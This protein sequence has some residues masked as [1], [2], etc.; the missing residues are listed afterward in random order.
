MLKDSTDFDYTVD[1]LNKELD[2][3]I[4]LQDEIMESDKMNSSLKSIES[5]LNTLYEKTRYLEDIIDYAKTFLTIKI[6]N[7][8]SD[9]D[10]SIKS[11]EDLSKINKNLG[12]I[13]YN[14]PFI[15][16][17]I[18]I[19]DRNKNY[20]ITPCNIKNNTLTLSNNIKDTYDYS[21]ITKKCEQVPH[22]NNLD[23][24]NT[25]GFY[26]SIYLEE[27][28]INKGVVETLTVYLKEPKEVNELNLTPVNCNIKNI[29][30]VYINGIEEQSGDLVTGIELESRIV[31]HIKFDIECTNYNIVQY[32][33]D[34]DKLTENTW[35][36]IKQLEY[37][38]IT[39]EDINDK[40]TYD[41]IIKKI[42]Y[43]SSTKQS[44]TIVY[45]KDTDNTETLTMYVYNFGLDLF[46]INRIVLYEDNYFLS[47]PI[48]IG[49]L[50]SDEYL[51]LYVDDNTGQYSNIEYYIVDGDKDVP[52]IPI[53]LDYVSNERIFPETDLRF[54][55]SDDIESYY[56]RIIKKD[57]IELS[58]SLEEAKLKYDGRY[59]VSYTPLIENTYTPLNSTVRVKAIIRTFG[60]TYDTIP[61]INYI[62]IRKFGGNALWT[63]LY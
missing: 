63:N 30:Y 31:T 37:P 42:E 1:L 7:Y 48:N 35:N 17:S 38:N 14:V 40:I 52:I 54:I 26:R 10:S 6:D 56:D 18:N 3:D 19:K 29:R 4:Q 23:T 43:N 28:P 58:I 33:V 55:V 44:N 46:E 34:K 27:K 36:K 9:I 11:I 32:V 39:D 61:Y 5:N 21:S 50:D 8:I 2:L 51:Q 25:D 12:Y 16:N 24:I 22:L 13:D 62:N 45:N 47:E 20:K 53:G 15:K 59:S 41:S 57:G 60:D 49:V